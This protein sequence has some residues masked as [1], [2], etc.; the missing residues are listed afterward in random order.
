M[1]NAELERVLPA[2]DA[3]IVRSANKVTRSML[4]ASPRL[5][6]VGRAGSGVDNIDLV[7]AAELGVPVVN[8]PTGNARS[9]AGEMTSTRFV[10][11]TFVCSSLRMLVIIRDSSWPWECCSGKMFR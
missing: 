1:S 9:V 8:S 2:Y 6:A 5:A 3:V 11:R 10:P 4:A 7:A